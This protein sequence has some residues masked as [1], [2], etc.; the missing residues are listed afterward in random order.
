MQGSN[1]AMKDQKTNEV[2]SLIKKKKLKAKTYFYTFYTLASIS[3]WSI[4][5]SICYYES[6]FNNQESCLESQKSEKVYLSINV[7]WPHLDFLW[8]F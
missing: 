6:Y 8:H 4:I 1:A 7:L 3:K 2:M 5:N